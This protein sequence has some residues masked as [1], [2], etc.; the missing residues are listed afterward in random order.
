MA[1]CP[2]CSHTLL[3]HVRGS[4]TYWFCR[5]CWQEMPVF[6]ENRSITFTNLFAEQVSSKQEISQAKQ[7][8]VPL[9][10]QSSQKE[11]IGVEELSELLHTTS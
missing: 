5:H 8:V 10:P 9:V 2:C 4:L 1:D 3:Q 11:W 7:V 6:S